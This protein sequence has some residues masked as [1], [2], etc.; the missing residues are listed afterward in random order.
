[1]TETPP[2]ELAKPG[3][4]DDTYPTANERLAR[5]ENKMLTRREI[6]KYSAMAGAACTLPGSLIN[7]QDRGDI[8]KRA[9][10]KTGEELPIVGL[11]SSATFSAK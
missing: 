10:P 9:I 3:S 5:M 11:G 2:A 7:A 8:I 4:V 6:L 1:M